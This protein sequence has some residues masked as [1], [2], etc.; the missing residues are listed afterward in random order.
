M[1][2]PRVRHH[3]KYYVDAPINT[4]KLNRASGFMTSELFVIWLKHFAKYTPPEKDR[5]VLL[6]L[7]NHASHRS[8]EA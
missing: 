5:P 4:L 8:I 7:D 1:S 6:I 2:I 3:A